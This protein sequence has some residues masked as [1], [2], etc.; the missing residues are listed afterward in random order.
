MAYFTA[1]KTIM[2]ALLAACDRGVNVRI[3]VP[4]NANFQNNSN[5]A[6]TKTLMKK[7]DSKIQ[8]FF[9]PKMLHTK[10]IY[11]EKTATFGSCNI[12]KKA[13][14]QLDELNVFIDSSMPI[15]EDIVNSAEETIIE[16]E[17]IEDWRTIKYNWFYS[18]IENMIV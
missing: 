13:F 12:T 11:S 5:K 6:T 15:Y 1:R 8:V 10:M 14:N 17:V 3:V 16:S 18:W 7:S 2:N 4:E 9:S